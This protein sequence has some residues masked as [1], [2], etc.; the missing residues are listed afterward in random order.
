MAFESMRGGGFIKR[1]N[2]EGKRAHELS[3]VISVR[4]KD[5]AYYVSEISLATEYLPKKIEDAVFYS[6]VVA[7][8]YCDSY[9]E[10]YLKS[11]C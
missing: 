3:L 9:A 1:Y 2:R 10:K 11:L 7:K 6:I 5:G 8:S 4:R